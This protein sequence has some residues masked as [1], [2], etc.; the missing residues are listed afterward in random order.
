MTEEP[1]TPRGGEALK[2]AIHVARERAG[3]TS[4]TQLARQAG[5]SYDTLMNWFGGRTLPRP[6]ELK[7]VA[8]AVGVRLVELMDAYEGRDPQPPSLEERMGELIDELRVFVHEARLQRAANEE[9][10]AAIL[11]AL[12]AL[13]R[14]GAQGPR[15]T[16]GRVEP[17]P[18]ADTRR[19]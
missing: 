11:R 13:G 15:E 17:G 10:T 9:S 18:A 6:T 2:T 14:A 8:D 7:R 1:Q 19:R 5:V 4:D 3:I 12:G 16:Q